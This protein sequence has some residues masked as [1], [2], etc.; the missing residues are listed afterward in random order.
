MVAIGSFCVQD[1]QI[2]HAFWGRLIP[3]S[4]ERLVPPPLFT[5]EWKWTSALMDSVTTGFTLLIYIVCVRLLLMAIIVGDISHQGSCGF[6]S[7][8]TLF[9]SLLLPVVNNQGA[10]SVC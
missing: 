6:G 2:E 7:T 4:L 8:L 3:P 5:V 9:K 10:R 1:D